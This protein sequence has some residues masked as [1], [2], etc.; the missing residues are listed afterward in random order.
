[1]YA[2][3]L[4]LVSNRRVIENELAL[5]LRQ[6]KCVKDKEKK[7]SRQAGNVGPNAQQW[8]NR[9][10]KHSAHGALVSLPVMRR[11]HGATHVNWMRLG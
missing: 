9:L 7:H 11:I 1:M 5:T 3:N 6:L 10:V 2:N 4:K 8:A